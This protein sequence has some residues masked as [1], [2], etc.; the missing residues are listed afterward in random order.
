[1]NILGVKDKRFERVDLAT[2]D[3]DLVVRPNIS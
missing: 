1:M 2:L 3:R